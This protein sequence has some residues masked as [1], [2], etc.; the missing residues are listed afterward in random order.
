MRGPSLP[1]AYPAYGDYEDERRRASADW[2]DAAQ[3]SVRLGKVPSELMALRKAGELSAV[4]LPQQR[5]ALCS[6]S[7]P[8]N[9]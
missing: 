5:A 8:D 4:G 2:L 3:L 9:L 1:P 7:M 6:Q